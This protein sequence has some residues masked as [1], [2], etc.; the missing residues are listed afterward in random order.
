MR[1]AGPNVTMWI[2]IVIVICWTASEVDAQAICEATPQGYEAMTLRYWQA[3]LSAGYPEKIEQELDYLW[4]RPSFGIAFS[5][6]GTRSASASWGQLRGLREAGLLDQAQYLSAVSGGAWAAIP[7]TFH[8]VRAP[9]TGGGEIDCRANPTQ[10]DDWFLGDYVP[11]EELK[12]SHLGD[13]DSFAYELS[14]TKLIRLYLARLPFRGD[15]TYSRAIGKRF[16]NQIGLYDCEYPVQNCTAT[17][18]PPRHR[19]FVAHDEQKEAL[20]KSSEQLT[21]DEFLVA[22]DDRPFLI[23]G[24]TLMAKRARA[25]RAKGELLPFEITP[26]YSGF[27]VSLK[28]GPDFAGTIESPG[29]DAHDYRFG[30]DGVCATREI[31]NRAVVHHRYRFA[32]SDA[33]GS[34]GAA[35]VIVLNKVGMRFGF[36]EFKT[37]SVPQSTSAATEYSF[38]DGGHLDNLGLTPLLARGVERIL[39]FVNAK[40]PFFKS[41]KKNKT[42]GVGRQAQA[43]RNPFSMDPK[44]G[45]WATG[46][47]SGQA[48]PL[49]PLLEPLDGGDGFARLKTTYETKKNEGE[50]L[51]HCEHYKAPAN[52]RLGIREYEPRVCFMF[53]DRAEEWA[54]AIKPGGSRLLKRLQT[55]KGG[56]WGK[57]DGFPHYA[58]FLH[59]YWKLRVIDLGEE[60]V[61]ALAHLTAWSVVDSADEIRSGLALP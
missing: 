29:Y 18:T 24:T 8:N 41:T 22:R 16:L 57:L 58:T 38:G 42:A 55:G 35:P 44:A 12:E 15:E 49:Q 30:E 4:Q 9:V 43:L 27:P 11:P 21:S 10:C 50:P 36:P 13:E 17:T 61:N 46:T 19:Y 31:K 26:L 34:T 6:G 52:A 59:R 33:L 32:L 14:T 53:L 47:V 20:A 2:V 3:P 28:A 39:V 48:G 54:E 25:K 51:L 37:P 23:V 60:Q 56:P 1:N 40:G 5:G 45:R 7:F